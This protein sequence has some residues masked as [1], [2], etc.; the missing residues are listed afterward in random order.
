MPILNGKKVSLEEV[1]AWLKT[2]PQSDQITY[3]IKVT[4]RA[5]RE[6]KKS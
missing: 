1:L 2:R 5:I 4:K 3:M 6:E